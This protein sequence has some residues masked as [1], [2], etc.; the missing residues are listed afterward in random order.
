MF[1]SEL[2]IVAVVGFV[3][4]IA[5]PYVLYP[6]VLY[7]IPG[8]SNR[9]KKKTDAFQP[10]VSVLIPAH[11]EARGIKTKIENTL[12]LTY[13]HDKLEIIVCS[14]HS[15]DDTDKLVKQFKD[16]RIKL[17]RNERRLGKASTINKMVKEARGELVLLTDATSKLSPQAIEVLKNAFEDPQVG[18]ATLRYRIRTASQAES[19]YWSFDTLVR[20][21]EM[22]KNMLLGVHGAAF[23]VR[24][25]LT[26][27]LPPDTI[28]DD[29]V[30]PLILRAQG[31]K[32][33]YLD[34]AEAVEDPTDSWRTIYRRLV[35]ITQ[36]NFQM[37]W[38][39]RNLLNPK[40]G[41]VALA[42][43]TRKLLK[44]LGPVWV[45]SLLLLASFNASEHTFGLIVAVSSWLAILTG[46]TGIL[47][48]NFGRSGPLPVRILAYGLMAQTAGVAGMI[49]ALLSNGNPLWKRA[50]ENEPLELDQP[51][52]PPW[53]VLAIKRGLDIVGS[54]IGLVLASPIMLA[55]SLAIWK[56]T[57]RPL[58]FRQQRVR[59]NALGQPIN[60]T[61][62]KFRTMVVDAEKGS[63]PVWASKEDPRITPLGNFLRKCRLDEIPQ[64]A[65]VF[66]GDMSLVGPRPE[67]SHFVNMLEEQIPLY[68]DRVYRLKPGITGWAQINL[69]YDTS[70]ESVRDKLF[71]DLTYAAHLYRLSSYL[72]IEFK[73][74]FS[75][76]KVM[77]TGK[78]AR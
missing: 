3:F 66:M 70:V 7:F 10:F 32:I 39:H 62:Y 41:R 69:D 24:K 75:T 25:Q 36:G 27:S 1:S 60:F 29:F 2:F 20:K 40:H 54:T 4:L 23:M 31:H 16:R 30:I 59:Y 72:R 67:R 77:I 73:I 44:S 26:P 64:L 61:M 50:P 37:Y 8:I 76:V 6:I 38:R 11:N 49:R 35:R 42:F 47:L 56:E 46:L 63:G 51:A 9:S 53:H 65:N 58:V 45:L 12:E 15:T 34:S 22:K 78:G 33:L 18:V 43:G 74:L 71:Y 5:A 48:R 14:D 17:L 19:D 55:V 52:M 57:G 28:N 13:P 21:L 68:N